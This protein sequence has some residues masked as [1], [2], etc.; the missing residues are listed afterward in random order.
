MKTGFSPYPYLVNM[1]NYASAK[2]EIATE[3][4]ENKYDLIHVETYYIMPNLPATSVPVLLAEQTIEYLVY[5]HYAET[6]RLWPLK[7]LLAVDVAKH[8]YWEKYYWNKAKKV[9]AMSLADKEKM[10]EIEPGL[11]VDIVPNGVDVDY[12]NKVIVSKRDRATILFVG[13]F[14]WLQNREA[15]EILVDKVW[16]LIK[17]KMSDV[18]LWIVGRSP[19]ERIRGMADKD[20]RV[21]D[22]LDDIRLAYQKST[23]L[24]APIFG[25]G[26]TRYKILEAMASELPVVTTQIGIEGIGAVNGTH[27][28]VSDDV[29]EL[30]KLALDIILQKKSAQMVAKKAKKLVDDNFAWT[31]ISSK[32]EEIYERT[33]RS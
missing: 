1:Y 11:D 16:P 27:A 20:I 13:N 25:G 31:K 21:S 28:L 7:P 2:N 5:K 8:K 3:L 12:F 18:Q 29:S 19:S 6:T 33:A 10:L 30:G 32:L 14:N 9:A 4:S 15:V 23:L 26:G 17:A 24:L 22:D